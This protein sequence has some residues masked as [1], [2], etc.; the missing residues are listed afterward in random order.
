[1][2]MHPRCS[3]TCVPMHSLSGACILV[4][5]LCAAASMSLGSNAELTHHP[6][7]ENCQTKSSP[8]NSGRPVS[9]PLPASLASFQG[10]SWLSQSTHVAPTSY[11]PHHSFS[12]CIRVSQ[13]LSMYNPN[14]A[15]KYVRLVP[16]ADCGFRFSDSAV[17]TQVHAGRVIPTWTHMFADPLQISARKLLWGL[18]LGTTTAL[19][20][21]ELASVRSAQISAV[22]VA[23]AKVFPEGY[24]RTGPPAR[25]ILSLPRHVHAR[26]NWEGF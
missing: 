12:L 7:P 24:P 11:T 18:P 26:T 9:P 10:A 2:L 25:Q 5:I 16:A 4:F 22:D 1:M 20:F 15:T 14:A 23:R 19:N 13:E 8:S 3:S 6:P 21:N 17:H